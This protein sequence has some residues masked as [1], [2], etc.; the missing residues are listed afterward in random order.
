[1]STHTMDEL[2]RN[3]PGIARAAD[4]E[5]SRTSAIKLK[6]LDC[7]GMNRESVRSC[8]VFRCALWPFRPYQDERERPAGIVPT[9]EEYTAAIAESG[10]AGNGDALAAHRAARDEAKAEDAAALTKAVGA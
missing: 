2:R 7:S 9:A 5:K 10:R 6:C 4:H 3:F 1:M 8:A